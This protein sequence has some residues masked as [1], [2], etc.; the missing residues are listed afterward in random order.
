MSFATAPIG[1]VFSVAN[2]ATP[3]SGEE[4]LWDGD[5]PWVT[6]ADLGKNGTVGIAS[7]SRSI[8][9]EGLDSC[10]TQIVP[11]G[12]IVLSIRAPIGHTGIATVPLCFN[13]GCR[14]LIPS[15]KVLTQFGYWSIIAAKPALQ[16]E[17]QGTTFQEL[18]RDKLRSVRIALPDLP[19]QRAIADFLDRETARIDLLIEKKQRLVALLGEKRSAA[20]TAAVTGQIRVEGVGI[21][22]CLITEGDGGAITLQERVHGISKPSNWRLDKLHKVLRVRKGHKNEGMKEDNLLSL[23]YG[24]IVQKNINS[25]DGLLPENFEGYQIVEPGNIVL[26]FTDLQNDKRSLRQGLVT[27][28]GIITSAYDAV[29]VKRDNDPRFWFYSLFA[30]DLAKHYYSLGGGV[31]Q[32]IKFSDFPNDWVYR[33]DLLTQRAIA[34]F[35]DCETARIQKI[36]E[37]TRQSIDRLRE[38]RS[39]LVTAAVTGQINVA[40][41][42]KAGTNER[43]L[44]SL[45]VEM[46]H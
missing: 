41:W 5:I 40:E 45:Q 15:K 19:T 43:Q 3:K 21:R 20:I 35:L 44:N 34:D 17:G 39:S 30:L 14:G 18:G 11:T 10:G 8:T 26:R 32:S 22:D 42:G 13:Q 29:E 12:T 1:M 25:S 38:Y 31:R 7:G 46:E 16:S 36:Q 27:Q 2:G 37:T 6:P 9:R 23:S 24:R 28:K 33:P 4:H